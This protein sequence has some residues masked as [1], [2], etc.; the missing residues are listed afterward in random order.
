MFDHVKDES[1]EPFD[2]DPLHDF[3]IF[4]LIVTVIGMVLTAR[5]GSAMTPATAVAHPTSKKWRYPRLVEFRRP[6]A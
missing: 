6:Q 3:K 1:H 4:A 5:D 2:I